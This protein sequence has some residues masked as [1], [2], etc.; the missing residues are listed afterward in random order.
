MQPKAA[1]RSRRA[2]Y[3]QDCDAA[4]PSTGEGLATGGRRALRRMGDR[5]A[6]SRAHGATRLASWRAGLG[7]GSG[8]DVVGSWRVRVWTALEHIDDVDIVPDFDPVGARMAG[9]QQTRMRPIVRRLQM[10]DVDHCGALPLVQAYEGVGLH[11]AFPIPPNLSA[12]RP[13]FC[14][15]PDRG[16]KITA[17]VFCASSQSGVTRGDATASAPGAVRR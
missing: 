10:R 13:G 5:A 11:A 14:P 16:A 17:R 2:L 9:Q 3:L 4:R 6:M 15:P 1:E 12:N 8:S 7:R